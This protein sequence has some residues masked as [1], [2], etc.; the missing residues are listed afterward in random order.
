[1]Q[2]IFSWRN[3]GRCLLAFGVGIPLGLAFSLSVPQAANAYALFIEGR[4]FS[5]MGTPAGIH[6]GLGHVLIII[7]NNL[8]P[9]ALGFLLPPLIVAYN[10]AYAKRRPEKYRKEAESKLRRA[11][12]RRRGKLC[13]ELYL[14][15][16]MF[17]YA[18]AF[19]FG[20]F[21]FGVFFGYLIRLGGLILLE[22]GLRDIGLHAPFE[23]VA[24]LMSASVA[25]GLRDEVLGTKP[26]SSIASA[27]LRDTLLPAI[28]SRRMALTLVLVVAMI[29]VGAFVEVYV[30]APVAGAGFG[31]IYR[32]LYA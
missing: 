4:V 14:N 17:G 6:L 20:F 19:A 18:L 9:V 24:I 28:G 31:N 1:M 32:L 26:I 15:L 10:L 27:R 30:S 8:V 29:V 7:S 11:S 12:V 2:L 13:S 16:S 23:V 3:F 5:T 21:V 22:R 25:L